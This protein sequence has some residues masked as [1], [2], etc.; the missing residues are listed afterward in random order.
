MLRRMLRNIGFTLLLLPEP[1]T[2]PFG[3]ALLGAAYLFAKSSRVDSPRQLRGL[4]SLYFNNARPVGQ[5]GKIIQHKLKQKLIDFEWRGSQPVEPENTNNSIEA[6]ISRLIL[7]YGET[8]SGPTFT[9]VEKTVHHSLNQRWAGY[10]WPGQ[11]QSVE[12]TENTVNH[13]ID[14]SRLSLRYSDMAGGSARGMIADKVIYHNLKSS[15]SGYVL[16]G[17]ALVPEKTIRHTISKAKLC[18]APVR[19]W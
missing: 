11:P 7:R 15:L 13:K 1:F 19:A 17:K 6:E 8:M 14:S 18:L 4:M 10:V 3:L 9:A 2:T 16:P 5:T 12:A